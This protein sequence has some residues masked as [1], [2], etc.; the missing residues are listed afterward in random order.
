MKAFIMAGGKGS[1]LTG[2]TNDTYPKPLIKLNNKPL[3]HYVIDNLI[4][5]GIDEIFVSV[6]H[7]HQQIE[8]YINSIT[9]NIKINFIIEP[10]PLGSAGA[11]YFLK[12]KVFDDFVICSGDTLF[13]I[14][15]KQMLDFHK[16]NHSMAT[17]FTHPNSHP[18]D[19]DLIVTNNNNRVIGIEKKSKLRNFYYNNNVNAGFFII[20]PATLDY[21]DCPKKVSM[22]HD[23][24]NHLITTNK[25]VF[26]YK[27]SEYIKDCGTPERYN[28]ALEDLKNQLPQKR[29]KQNKQKAIF[30][31]RDGT[32]NEYRGHVANP[33]DL[34][35]IENA[36]EAIKLI[37]KSEYLAIVITNQPVIA[38]GQCTFEEHDE[39]VRKL[40][41]ELG[42]NGAYLDAYYFC[43]HHPDSGFEGEIK[44][45]K[46]KCNCRKPHIGM[47]EHA[48]K[49]FNLDLS[50]CYFIGDTD[51][52][53]RTGKNANTKTIRVLSSANS[54]I[55]EKPD[56]Q[57]DNIFIAVN[58]ILGEKQ[59]EN[60]NK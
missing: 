13:D 10:E 29:N 1:R 51:I 17:L 44:E 21:F 33:A 32:I 43:P 25:R 14:D 3:I 41:T 16:K 6:G 23:F 15:I 50:Q 35:L 40:E 38:R 18:Y 49:D 28:Q 52:D 24:I 55:E 4:A 46:I 5:N 34:E 37:N 56:L 19:S 8:N 39:I 58:H 59:L 36:G 31:D 60:I 7:L 9:W 26:S 53:I 11:L 22:E 45:L 30:L 42:K 54:I 48:R 47:L 12:G 57:F 2:L 20:N 27:S